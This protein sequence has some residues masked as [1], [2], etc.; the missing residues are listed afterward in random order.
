MSYVYLTVESLLKS[1][2][3]IPIP[4]FSGSHLI[5]NNYFD[6]LYLNFR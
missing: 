6:I 4:E 3:S 1:K 2:S 5:A